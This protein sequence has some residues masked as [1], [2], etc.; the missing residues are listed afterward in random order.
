[1]KTCPICKGQKTIAIVIPRMEPH[2]ENDEPSGPPSRVENCYVCQG[3]GQITELLY[4]I[5]R[6]RGTFGSLPES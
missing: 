3:E 4:A 2:D 1:M 6:A 5:E